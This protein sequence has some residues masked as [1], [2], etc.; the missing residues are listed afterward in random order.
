LFQKWNFFAHLI[1]LQAILLWIMMMLDR[2]I[3]MIQAF[4]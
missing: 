3:I 4:V 1:Q 2:N